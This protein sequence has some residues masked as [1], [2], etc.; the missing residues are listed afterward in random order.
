MFVIKFKNIDVSADF[1]FFAVLAIFAFFDKSGYGFL[2]LGACLCHELAHI[3]SML[4][5]R[6]RFS[7][8]ALYGCGVSILRRP[9]EWYGFVTCGA[10][11]FA[12]FILFVIFWFVMPHGNIYAVTFALVNLYVGLYNLIPAGFLDGKTLF[13][14]LLSLF[15]MRDTALSV[16]SSLELFAVVFGLVVLVFSVAVREINIVAAG[17]IFFFSVY[18]SVLCIGDKG[19]ARERFLSDK[20]DGLKR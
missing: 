4:I 13:Y 18:P 9:D 14:R 2:S 16:C 15:F 1:S 6:E 3:F 12:N 17:M 10:G 8:I 7:G 20:D 5:R 11:C 19:A